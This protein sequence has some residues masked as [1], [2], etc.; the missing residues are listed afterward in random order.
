MVHRSGGGGV[1]QRKEPVLADA[2]AAG[3]DLFE[4]PGQHHEN[5]PFNHEDEPHRAHA[6]TIPVD[7]LKP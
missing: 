7:V 2:S 1:L 4:V 6:R 3:E 5:A